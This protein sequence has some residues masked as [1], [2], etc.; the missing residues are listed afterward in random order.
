[1][2][3]YCVVVA[4]G[5]RARFFTLEHS[6][7]PELESGPNLV[8]YNQIENTEMDTKS[9]ALWSENKSGRNRGAKGGSAHGYDDHRSQHE[10][11]YE[12]RFANNIAD[13]ARRFSQAHKISDMIV[14]SQKRMLGFLRSAIEPRFSGIQTQELAKDLSKLNP[15]EL[16]EH[17]AKEKLIPRRM[18]PMAG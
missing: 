7:Y 17:L 12:R 8:E 14:V 10:D 3:Q 2:N 11:E 1:M 18:A 9:G 6:K 16:H 5:A 13:E 15:I 4:N